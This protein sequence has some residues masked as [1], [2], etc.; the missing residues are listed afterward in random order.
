MRAKLLSSIA[1]LGMVAC[2][3]GASAPGGK[4][5][6]EARTSAIPASSGPPQYLVA[7]PSA[8]GNVVATPLG[9][10]GGLGLVVDKTRI[11][12]GRGEP[13]VGA[14]LPDQP[15]AGTRK[16][17][18]R[19]GG[20]FLFWTDAVLYRAD[21]FDGTLVPIARVPDTIENLAF[22]PKYLLVRTRNGERWAMSPTTGERMAIEPLGA[23]DCEGLDDGR[24]IAFNDQGT[25]FASNDHGQH[26]VDVTSQVKSSPTRVAV[27]DEEI[28]LFESS[29]SAL[30]L[31]ADGQ[32]SSFDKQPP[33]KAPELR[34]RDAR[35]RGA[36]APLRSVFHGG[37]SIDESTA[38][39]VEQGDLVRIDVHTGEI[40]GIASGKLPPDARCEAVPTAHDVLFACI[41]RGAASY[42][43]ASAFVVSHTLSG[44]APTVEQTFGTTAQFFGSD[45]GGLAFAGPCSGAPSSIQDHAV[46]VRQPGGTWQDFDLSALG[47]DAGAGDVTVARWVPR[48]DGRVVAL[49]LDPQPGIF[50]PRTGSFEVV[51]ADVRETLAQGVTPAY[52]YKRHYAGFDGGLVDYN[53]S[54]SSTGTLRGWQRRGGGVELTEDGKATRSPYTFDIVTAGPYALGR[55]REGRL[56]QSIDHGASWVEVAA[57]PSGAAAGDLRGCST[58]GCDL[59]G[60]YRVGWAAR[61]PRPEAPQTPARPAPAIRRTRPVELSCRPAGPAQSKALPRTNNS[62]DD[63]GLGMN[64]LQVAGDRDELAFVRAPIARGIVNPIHDTGGSGDSDNPALR[65]LLS[66]F[67]T[68]RDGDVVTVLGP[69][70]N[71]S[72]LRRGFAFVPAFDPA[73]PVKKATIAMSDVISVGRAAGMST[74]EVLQDDMTESGTILV[75]TPQDPAA[76][77]DLAFYNPRGL[78]AHVRSNERVKLAMR[79]AQNEGTVISGVALA[80][81]EVAFLELESSGVGHVFKMGAPAGAVVDLFDVSPTMNDTMFYPANPDALAIGPK[82]E[83]AI[84][85]TGS[86]S[87]PA[88]IHDPALLLVPAM[89][90]SP[91]A[92][93][94]TL[95]TM[96]DPACKE[97]GYRATIQA[98]APWIRVT[99]PELRVTD[100]MPMLARVRWSDKRVC[101]EGVEVKLP[102]VIV[103]APGL[104]GSESLHVASWLVGR[105]TTFARVA[106]AEGVEWRQPLECAIVAP[107]N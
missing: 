64:K 35:W 79:V 14:D 23:V 58:A 32:L 72:A 11:V 93:W 33:E 22:A 92:P 17:P 96:D 1:V 75:V 49:L 27:V 77:G 94:S 8:R 55:T 99:T 29:G 107:R 41:S 4:P 90:P 65:A 71:A 78:L 91:L 34:A 30:R 19:F 20:G 43:A 87:D 15:I 83:L 46:C 81:D 10:A 68:N 38:I 74:E 98:I 89:P 56:Y 85:R 5:A 39:V 95:R 54:F 61:P 105:G 52:R 3:H 26:W 97:P 25:A 100:E 101:L 82:N 24:A 2:A 9:G 73:A 106:I 104:A 7:D 50:D 80:G 60:F 28:W 42:G 44:D 45:D 88:S 62:P 53:W 66:G 12:I 63:L 6:P 67:S 103:R 76:S 86:G 84:V 47:G 18:G 102:D 51:D 13:R 37:A 40:V 36:E 21:A 70:K 31:E 59:G 48:A 16:I 69:N 57:P